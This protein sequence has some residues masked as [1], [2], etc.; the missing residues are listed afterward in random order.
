M[1]HK[2]SLIVTN[3]SDQHTGVGNFMN[4]LQI[5]KKQAKILPVILASVAVKIDLQPN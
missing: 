5:N 3:N 4:L 2:Y 1:N